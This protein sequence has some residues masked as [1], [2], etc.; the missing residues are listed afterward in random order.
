MNR[1][2]LFINALI[3]IGCF[4]AQSQQ[5]A[6]NWF[7]VFGMVFSIVTITWIIGE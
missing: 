7:L 6:V 3:F 2:L 1:L 4:Y 5:L